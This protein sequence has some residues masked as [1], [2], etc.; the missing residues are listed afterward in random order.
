M[1]YQ[2]FGMAESEF[3]LWLV[4]HVDAITP[5]RVPSP[6]LPPTATPP[7]VATTVEPAVDVVTDDAPEVSFI[8]E[9]QAE[10]EV[11]PAELSDDALAAPAEADAMWDCA[12]CTLLN[13]PHVHECTVCGTMRPGREATEVGSNSG[14]AAGADAAAGWWCSSC[15]FINPLSD[16]RYALKSYI[17]IDEV[18]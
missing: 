6:P 3:V 13:P 9:V 4:G 10:A 16:T 12:V 14:A 2:V 18:F 15:T 7:I 8:E 17:I 11:P 1:Q 5:V